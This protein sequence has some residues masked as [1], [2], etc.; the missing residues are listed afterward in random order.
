TFLGVPK[1]T[2]KNL[3]AEDIQF[4]RYLSGISLDE[5]KVQEMMGTQYVSVRN[6]HNETLLRRKIGILPADFNIEIK[7]GELA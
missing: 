2:A 5:C 6:T 3:N 1:V 7:G 4:K